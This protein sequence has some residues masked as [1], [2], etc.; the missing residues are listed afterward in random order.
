MATDPHKPRP[1]ETVRKIAEQALGDAVEITVLTALARQQNTG[2]VNKQLDAAGAKRAASAVQNALIARLVTLIARAYAEPKHGDLHLRA[3]LA[4]L[5][6]NATRQIFTTRDGGKEKVAEFEAHFAKCNGDHRQAQITHFRHKYTAHLGEPEDI[7]TP[8]YADVFAFGALT[9]ECM[10][11]LAL[12]T[13]VAVKP[14]SSD[15]TVV[16]CAEA[17]WKPWKEE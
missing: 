9:A 16:S 4:L 10:E 12:A 1:E 11:L 15:P 2:G 17:F 13:G 6:N 14:I 5:K 3:V 7:E 8:A